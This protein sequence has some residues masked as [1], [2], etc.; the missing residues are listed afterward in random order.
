MNPLDDNKNCEFAEFAKKLGYEY[1]WDFS[2]RD[3]LHW[4]E[5][6]KNKKL[7]LQVD[8]KV[9]LK[10]IIEGICYD[11]PDKV[12]DFFIASQEPEWSELQKKVR[13]YERL[14]IL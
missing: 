3:G 14:R 4:H 10:K 5:L 2:K 6:W 7:C 1:S 12:P 13:E 9:P 8:M 11:G